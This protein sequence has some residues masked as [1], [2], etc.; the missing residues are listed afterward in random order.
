[1]KKIKLSSKFVVQI[2]RLLEV[3]R[4]GAPHFSP[5]QILAV[6]ESLSEARSIA[7]RFPIGPTVDVQ[8]LEVF[9]P[10]DVDGLALKFLAP[11]SHPVAEPKALLK[12]AK[13]R[14]ARKAA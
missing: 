6:A 4:G 7:Q 11:V 12:V 14:K 3:D 5:A 2:V 10:L 8:I 1:M 13:A 9:P